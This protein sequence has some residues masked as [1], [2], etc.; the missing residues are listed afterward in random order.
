[1][2]ARVAELNYVGIKRHPSSIPKQVDL[3]QAFNE[4][5]TFTIS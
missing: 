3:A 5:P 4:L 1:M 2:F